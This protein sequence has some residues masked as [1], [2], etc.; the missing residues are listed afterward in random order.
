MSN[1]CQPPHLWSPEQEQIVV[2]MLM[3]G[4]SAS[5]IAEKFHLSR[6]AVIGRIARNPELHK[7]VKHRLPRKVKTRIPLA[8]KAAPMKVEHKPVVA[9]VEPMR[10][11]PLIETGSLFCKWPVEHDD[12]VIGGILCCGR[13]VGFGLVYCDP[14]YRQAHPWRP[15]DG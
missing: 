12:T 15:S 7:H 8:V 4:V 5:G 11:M 10:L 13:K 3:E 14:H 6:N 9:K 2:T 1:L